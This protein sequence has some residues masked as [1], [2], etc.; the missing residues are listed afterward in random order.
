MSSTFYT[1]AY[2]IWEALKT[3][4]PLGW[5]M[6]EPDNNG[7]IITTVDGHS[8]EISVRRVD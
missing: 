3:A 8:Y 1:I 7:L 6:H 5:T 4:A 2:T